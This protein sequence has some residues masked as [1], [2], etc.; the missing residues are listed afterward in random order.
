MK[1][2][3]SDCLWVSDRIVLWNNTRGEQI[4]K[5]YT[6]SSGRCTHARFLD[7]T[8]YIAGHVTQDETDIATSPCSEVKKHRVSFSL[9]R[10][11]DADGVFAFVPDFSR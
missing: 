5:L 9:G 10:T 4:F 11:G 6:N 8:R 7:R 2:L 1:D 3:K